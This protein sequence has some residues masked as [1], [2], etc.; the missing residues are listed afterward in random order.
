[1]DSLAAYRDLNVRKKL[2]VTRGLDS[3]SSGL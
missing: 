3:K 1:L 2:I